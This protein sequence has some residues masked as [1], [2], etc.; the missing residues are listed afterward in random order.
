MD[1]QS[2][3]NRMA[4]CPDCLGAP[5]G[6]ENK[7]QRTITIG[8]VFIYDIYH[9]NFRNQLNFATYGASPCMQQGERFFGLQL[10]Y[11]QM[12]SVELSVDYGQDILSCP[13]PR[14]FTETV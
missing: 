3:F 11:S 10:C 4:M 1:S 6:L 7:A 12:L 5:E 8:V 13:L 14:I 2:G 9:L